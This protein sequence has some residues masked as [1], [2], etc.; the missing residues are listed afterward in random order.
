M[1]TP[2]AP[3]ASTTPAT[4]ATPV[5]QLLAAHIATARRRTLP[6]EVVRKTCLHVLDT[7]AAMVSGT[8]LEAG[9]RILPWAQGQGGPAQAQVVGSAV[10][11]HA[12]WAALA[13]GV[14]AHADET[15]DSHALS[16]THPGCA[17]VPAALA[18]AEWLDVPGEVL[19]RAVAAGY[20]VGP[21]VSQALGGERL[22]DRHHSS[23]AIGG[24]FGASAATAVVM[25]FDPAHCAYMLAY[26]VQQ[27]SGNPCWR[28]DPEHVE[29]A[30]DFGGM[31]AYQAVTAA[32]LV[33]AGFTGSLEPL[34]GTPGLFAAHAASADITL[35]T[36][37][38][39]ERYEV[40][41][42]AIKKW[43]VGSPIQAALDST[44]H[45]MQ[46]EGLRAADVARIAVALPRQSAPVVD[47][48]AMPAVNLQFQM[49]SLLSDGRLTFE[50]THDTARMQAPDIVALCDRIH[51]DARPEQ[52]F[53]DNS[54][55]AIVTAQLHDGRT[56]RHHT[57][58]VRGTPADPMTAAEVQDKARDLMAPVL[59][60][61][62]T[63][64][65]I[66]QLTHLERLPRTSDLR[67]LLMP[68]DPA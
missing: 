4:P 61:P 20:D 51:I 67:R 57:L 44:L 63:N 66:E 22:F 37:A 64:A 13:G 1:V 41:R 47:R 62:T 55:Q 25:D 68:G 7:V 45:L 19:V 65:L 21:R 2:A 9:L 6:P 11:T 3:K 32:T 39:G 26:A 60:L 27:A 14:L 52:A 8:R 23:H 12:A 18:V 54:R 49:A 10:R 24:L 58:H 38:L 17:I 59:G 40:M 15:D 48:R 42:T 53:I 36:Q 34:E 46:H 28:R 35:A 50:S 56:L 5:T 30:F 29:K 33:Q 31:P 16:L 43:C